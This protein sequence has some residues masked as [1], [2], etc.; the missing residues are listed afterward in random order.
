VPVFRT[1]LVFFWGLII[2]K[3]LLLQWLIERYHAPING[4]LFVWT[5]SCLMS[6]AITIYFA[7]RVF[8]ELP[9]M[10]LSGRLVSATWA[11]CGAAFLV[12]AAAAGIYGVFSPF[13]LPA[14]AAVL[15]GVGCYIHSVADRRLLFKVTG[16]LWWLAAM[17]LFTQ[18]GWNVL[19]WMSLFMVLL[20]VAP[21]AWLYWSGQRALRAR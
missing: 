6:G 12:L 16:V 4:P 17:W 15:L 21:A 8:R 9:R 1:L 13:L 19:I 2:A 18:V 20:L 5:P 10:P 11:A 7:S 3:C 14:L